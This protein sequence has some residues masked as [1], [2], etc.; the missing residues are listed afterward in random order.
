MYCDEHYAK[1]VIGQ[2]VVLV[3]YQKEEGQL[4]ATL[5]WSFFY[6]EKEKLKFGTVIKFYTPA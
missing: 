6:D 2:K 3:Y 4:L 1:K 5:D